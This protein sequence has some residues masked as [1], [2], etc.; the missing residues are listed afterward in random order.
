MQFQYFT[1]INENPLYHR[2]YGVS[3]KQWTFENPVS[4]VHVMSLL[5]RNNSLQGP[6]YIVKIS[7]QNL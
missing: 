3:E 4:R 2:H 1:Q 5:P 6:Y 7:A